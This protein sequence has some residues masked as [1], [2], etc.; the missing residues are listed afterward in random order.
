MTLPLWTIPAFPLAGFLLLALVPLAPRAIVFVGCAS[1]A[2][3]G[4]AS[5]GW[6]A[7]PGEVHQSLGTWVAAGSLTVDFRFH[8]DPLARLMLGVITGVGFLIHLYSTAHMAGDE[9]YRRFFAAMNLFVA[10]MILLVLADNLVLL[11]LG[12]EGVGLCSY[13]L[14]GHW[15]RD[16]ANGAAARKAFI[17]TRT[18]DTALLLGLFLLAGHAGTLDIRTLLAGL[19]PASPWLPLAALLLLGGAVGKSAQV[20]LQV[21]LPDAMAG[22]TPVSALIHAA[23]MVTAGAYLLARLHPLYDL[24]PAVQH[25]VAWLGAATLLLAGCSAL[26]QNDLKRALAYSTISQTGYLFLGLGVGAWRASAFHLM[27][28]AFFKALLFL[29]AGVVIAALGHTRDL[30]QMGG[31]RRHLPLACWSF[32]AGVVALAGLLPAA[33]YFSKEAILVRA[34]GADPALWAVAVAGVLVTALYGFRLWL[35]VFHG[36]LRRRPERAG[37]QPPAIAVPLIVLSLLSLGGG[38]LPPLPLTAVPTPTP[39][40]LT[41]MAAALLGT[42]LALV[43]WGWQPRW[44]RRWQATLPVQLLAAWWRQGWGFDALYHHLFVAPYRYLARLNRADVV[45]RPYDLLVGANA[46]VHRALLPLHDGRLRRY[47][48][49]MGLGAALLLAWGLGT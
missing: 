32:L 45:N 13:L 22:P 15:Y 24:V 20:P 21:W 46:A 33:G 37:R 38:F 28:H 42:V 44:W 31:L 35:R 16:P 8:L 29:A 10:A 5:L 7:T 25:G 17:V 4:L 12:W 26:A 2:L 27:T 30:G 11:Y 19:D 1:V 18:G 48:L 47:A 36:E 49:A 41:G 14:I 23:T 34:Y 3:A 40:S 6:I 9:G 39:V 43:L